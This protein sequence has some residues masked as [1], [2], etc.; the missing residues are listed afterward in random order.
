MPRTV[1]RLVQM[2]ARATLVLLSCC[3]MLGQ[4]KSNSITS[5]H[6]LEL[7]MPRDMVLAGLAAGYTLKEAT[8]APSDAKDVDLWS[9][10]SGN[11]WTGEVWFKAGKLDAASIILY[12]GGGDEP[13]LV[14]R[15][16]QA[17]Y[18]QSGQSMIEEKPGELWR[19]RQAHVAVESTEE[20]YGDKAKF[21]TLK[22]VIGQKQFN[23][24]V[25]T[26]LEGGR[27][28]TFREVILKRW[29]AGGNKKQVH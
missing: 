3:P 5:I 11:A 13:E 25:D 15:L 2:L 24:S 18:D 4:T 28:V 27:Y 8:H 7:G 21:R 29:Q 22:F 9:V 1:L 12:D 19:T 6:D 16:F 17:I 10:L 20:M 14:N 26:K 23:L